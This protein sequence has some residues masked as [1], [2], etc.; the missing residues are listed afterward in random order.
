MIFGMMPT[1]EAE[2]C[3]L[4]HAVRQGEVAFKK[5]RVL[6]IA[7]LDLLRGQGIETVMVC[8][9]EPGDVEEDRAAMRVAAVI[10]GPLIEVDEAFTGRVN[11]RAKDDGVLL[12]D[13]RQ[14]D[15][16]NAV[17]EVITLATLPEHA[18]VSRGQMLATVKII[19]FAVAGATLEKALRVAGEGGPLLDVAAFTGKEVTLIQTRLPG[20]KESVL[21]KTVR[22][23]A[24]RLSRLKARLVSETRCAHETAELAARLQT[25]QGDLVLIAG[26]SAITDRRDVLPS[27]IMAAGGTVDHLGM[28]VDPGNLLLLGHLDDRP[29]I[30]L[31]GCARSP[32]LNGFDWVLQRLLA[33]IEIRGAD[34]MAMGVGGLLSEIPSRPQPREHQ[35]K[36]MKNKVVAI[37][38]AAGQ[39]TRMGASN[40]LLVAVDGRPM[41]LHALDAMLGSRVDEVILV[42]GHEADLVRAALGDRSPRVV[43]NPDYALGLSTSLKAALS[44]LPAE[45]SGVLIGLGDMPRITTGDI[46]RLIA[47]FDPDE[48]RSICVP[49][50]KGK[51]GNPVLFSTAFVDDMLTIEGDVGAKHL[52][53]LHAEQVVEIEMDSD[54]TLIDVDTKEALAALTS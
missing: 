9:L 36:T 18:V 37:L 21:D 33:G 10:Q 34:I 16:L 46:D 43:H 31:P 2:G 40:K 3:F 23:T 41:V 52:I 38:L 39:S 12:L 7:D 4:A 35:G 54:A 5:G 26:A 14:I 49:T 20:I 19:P 47:A 17:D 44:A 51:R 45:I 27:A 22:V 11:L 32:K 53:G 42:T 24:S 6:A 48:G 50:V 8:R 28:P 1:D 29:V 15:R 13:R 30:G 25:A